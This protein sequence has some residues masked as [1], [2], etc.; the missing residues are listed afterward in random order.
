M[1]WPTAATGQQLPLGARLSGPC[2]A[3]P[4]ANLTNIQGR[5]GEVNTGVGLTG[6]GWLLQHWV[7]PETGSWSTTISS[8]NGTVCLLS[9]GQGWRDLPREEPE[10]GT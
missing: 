10:E 7:N 6:G 4:Y 2:G 1:L 9:A 3:L 8:P 5:Y